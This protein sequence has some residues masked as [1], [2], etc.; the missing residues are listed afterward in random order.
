MTADVSL[1][2]ILAN[3]EAQIAAHQEREAFHAE[4]ETYHR[5]HREQHA[6]ELET[7]TK[8]LATFRAAAGAAMELAQRPGVSASV[9]PVPASDPDPGRKPRLSRMVALVVESW[10][11]GQV[12][13][14]SAITTEVSRRYRD[15]LR[16]PPDP[17]MVSVH[18]RRLL[19]AGEIESVEEGRPHHEARYS[20]PK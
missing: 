13:G 9:L 4:Q 14:T 19:A 11:V 15:R 17:R 7:L 2:S 3:L 5:Q 18:L 16:R 8:N 12:F 1:S 10:P 6:A 20:R